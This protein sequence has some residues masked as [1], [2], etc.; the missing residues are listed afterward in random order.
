MRR[1][2]PF[3]SGHRDCLGKLIA[4][5]DIAGG[6][7]LLLGYG[8]VQ[9]SKSMTALDDVDTGSFEP[10][11][12]TAGG[13]HASRGTSRPL[14]WVKIRS[15]IAIMYLIYELAPDSSEALWQPCTEQVAQIRHDV[16]P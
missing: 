5:L 3:S 1:Y 8:V 16:L 11:T 6:Y 13:L 7:Q 10:W 4:L 14:S 2:F 12:R 9:K 15:G